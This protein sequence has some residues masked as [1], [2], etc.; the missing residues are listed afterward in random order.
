M[1][2][3]GGFVIGTLRSALLNLPDVLNPRRLFTI[4]GLI[5]A[6]SNA[7]LVLAGGPIALTG[8]GPV[9]GVAALRGLTRH[10]T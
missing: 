7:A 9:F 10:A 2:V 1:A 5:G 3:Q 4:G 6:L 8:P